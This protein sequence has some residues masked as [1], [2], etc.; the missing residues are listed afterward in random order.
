MNRLSRLPKT[1]GSAILASN[2]LQ[3]P[4][5][6]PG[7]QSKLLSETSF[8][9]FSPSGHSRPA[10]APLALANRQS[11]ERERVGI[12]AIAFH[13]GVKPVERVSQPAGS[14]LDGSRRVWKP[15]RG[16]VN[17]RWI[18]GPEQNSGRTSCRTRPI[19]RWPGFVSGGGLTGPFPVD[20]EIDLRFTTIQCD[21]QRGPA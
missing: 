16:P 9:R 20:D 2:L 1:I 3:N 6:P 10:S 14:L 7:C 19:S 4:Y 15:A 11:C 5:R 13:V 18:T 21:S 17:D 8:L 12:S